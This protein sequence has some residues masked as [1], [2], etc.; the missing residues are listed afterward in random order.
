[1]VPL[2]QHE[3]AN[4]CDFAFSAREAEGVSEA[5]GAGEGLAAGRVYERCVCLPGEGAGRYE[6]AL[7]EERLRPQ[8]RG[9]SPCRAFLDQGREFV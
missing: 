3:T 6:G 5:G 4:F 8:R 1:M 9:R 7:L 2:V